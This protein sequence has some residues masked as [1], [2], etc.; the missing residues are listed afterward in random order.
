MSQ[1][2]ENDFGG[3]SNTG[4]SSAGTALTTTGGASGTAAA[5]TEAGL[6][7]RAREYGQT[8]ADAA[9][10]AKEYLSDGASVVG[11]K[12]QDLHDVGYAEYANQAKD[13]ARQNPGQSLLIAAAVGF[14][15]GFLIRPPGDPTTP[16]PPPRKSR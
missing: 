12:L 3:T 14:V 10:Q 7:A 13:Y 1:N 8:V 9:S 4:G 15:V 6:A 11:D 5:G 2:N 16:P